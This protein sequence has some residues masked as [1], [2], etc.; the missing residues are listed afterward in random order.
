MG[1]E[2]MGS[3]R[4]WTFAEQL[5]KSEGGKRGKDYDMG[6]ERLDHEVLVVIL[7]KDT[8]F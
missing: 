4:R 8:D 1:C 2:P 5:N 3:C 7:D 6:R